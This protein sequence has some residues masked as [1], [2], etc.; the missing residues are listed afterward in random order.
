MDP[1]RL[2]CPE[3]GSIHSLRGHC[4][5]IRAITSENHGSETPLEPPSEMGSEAPVKGSRWTQGRGRSQDTNPQGR[6]AGAE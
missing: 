6:E 3:P 5:G 4:Q 2:R 1:R